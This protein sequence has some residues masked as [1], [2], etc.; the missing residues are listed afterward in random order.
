MRQHGKLIGPHTLPSGN[1]PEILNEHEATLRAVAFAPDDSCIAR[2]ARLNVVVVNSFLGGKIGPDKI[3]KCPTHLSCLAFGPEHK[4]MYL[5]R[6]V[7]LDDDGSNS[8]NGDAADTDG[9]SNSNGGKRY[10]SFVLA[11]GH[12]NGSIRL[13]DSWSTQIITTLIVVK[14]L[15]VADQHKRRPRP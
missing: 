12:K 7:S 1:L 4:N 9:K 3:I 10:R 13:W 11:T 8:R 14:G 6:S 5:V 2:I 15:R